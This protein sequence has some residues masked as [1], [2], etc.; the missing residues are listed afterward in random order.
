MSALPGPPPFQADSVERLR[1][2]LESWAAASLGEL[3]PRISTEF[4]QHDPLERP[5]RERDLVALEPANGKRSTAN[6]THQRQASRAQFL[7][8][9][10]PPPR[11]RWPRPILRRAA[12]SRS[13]PLSQT[14][15]REN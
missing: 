6:P 11:L 5:P 10:E 4:A 14:G 1:F 9:A 3:E 7:G 2:K 12:P 13:S 15:T 8:S